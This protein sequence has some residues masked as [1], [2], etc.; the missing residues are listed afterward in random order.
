MTLVR[1]APPCASNLLMYRTM[2]A[3]IKQIVTVQAGGL[4]QLCSD[5]LQEG[6]TVEVIVLTERAPTTGDTQ[7]KVNCLDFAGSV[8]SGDVR[9][10][11]NDA[12]DADLGRE[13]GDDNQ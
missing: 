13:S 5:E 2:F 6:S 7:A 4:V 10:A 1:D 3:V 11:H 8:D 9:T 12:M